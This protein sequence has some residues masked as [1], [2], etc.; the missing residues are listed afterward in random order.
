MEDIPF[1]MLPTAK[2][3]GKCD[4]FTIEVEGEEIHCYVATEFKRN[5]V[6]SCI[7]ARNGQK[8]LVRRTV[9]HLKIESGNL[10]LFLFLPSANE[11]AER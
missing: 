6:R 2:L 10:I 4:H 8:E 5:Q 3:Y 11:V 1:A 9:C 7:A